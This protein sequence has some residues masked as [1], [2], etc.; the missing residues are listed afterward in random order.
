LAEPQIVIGGM[1]GIHNQ[2]LQKTTE[3]LKKGR[4][5]EN[6]ATALVLPTRGFIHH[7]VVEALMGLITPPNQPFIRLFISGMEVG[8]AYNQAVEILLNNP[9]FE[10]FKYML[11]VEEDNMPPPDG[12]L[13]LLETIK[14][15]KWSA[16][17]GLYYTKGE[18]GVAQIW[19]D[20]A[21]V[22]NFRP[23]VPVPDSVQETHGL[24]QG[25]TLIEIDMFRDEKIPRPWFKTQASWTPEQGSAV[26]TQDLY[27]FG[28]AR[29]AGHR[30]A[31]DTRVKVGHLDT[32]TGVVW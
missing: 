19:G 25:F 17:G 10:G 9:G 8:D 14:D 18:E 30:V 4:S 12:L 13:R 3:R 1:E 29:R 31:V 20:P 6:T 7:R 15:P 11:C 5:Y 27:F 21:D 16:V 2:D 22:I 28:N 26:G 23:Q 32:K 24:G